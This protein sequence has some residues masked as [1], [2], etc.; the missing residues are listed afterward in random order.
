VREEA[1]AAG[2]DPLDE[3]DLCFL[4]RLEDA[5]LALLE[6]VVD[7]PRRGGSLDR[8]GWMHAEGLL[9]SG[10]W[11]SPTRERSAEGRT[12]GGVRATGRWRHR[13]VHGAHLLSL[14]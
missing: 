4:A 1:A 9:A 2:R 10:E 14:R 7:E 6:G 12:L 11:T 3:E 8:Q 13:G 5:E